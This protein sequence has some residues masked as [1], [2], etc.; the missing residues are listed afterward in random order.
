[1]S[2]KLPIGYWLKRV[3]ELITLQSNAALQGQGLSRFDWQVLNTV[4]ESESCDKQGLAELLEV[5]IPRASF[6]RIVSDFVQKGW[7]IQTV[8][9]QLHPTEAGKL[10]RE[11]AFVLQQRVRLKAFEG[12]SQDE[13]TMLVEVLQKV[14]ANLEQT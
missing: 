5:F 4:S 12:V 2:N 13:Y 1:M 11:K 14:V 3:D 6:E 9:G 10:A 7:L 8:D